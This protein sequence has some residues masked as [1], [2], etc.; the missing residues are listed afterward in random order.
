MEHRQPAAE[1]FRAEAAHLRHEAERV[2]TERYAGKSWTL[3]NDMTNAAIV[4]NLPRLLAG[5]YNQLT[6]YPEFD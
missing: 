4:E 6:H 2:R 1:R 5:R 3:R